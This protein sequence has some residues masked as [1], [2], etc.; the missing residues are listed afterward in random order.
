[1]PKTIT[2]IIA[3]NQIIYIILNCKGLKWICSDLKTTF[4]FIKIYKNKQ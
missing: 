2:Y 3:I 4:K 1:M